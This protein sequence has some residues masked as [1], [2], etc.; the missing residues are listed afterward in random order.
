MKDFEYY[1]CL[2]T[3]HRFCNLNLRPCLKNYLYLHRRCKVCRFL[4][5]SF[6]Y[7]VVKSQWLSI[8][9]VIFLWY[10]DSSSKKQCAFDLFFSVFTGSLLLGPFLAE[11]D[12]RLKHARRS[13]F[14]RLKYNSQQDTAMQQKQYKVSD[15]VLE[16]NRLKALGQS[17]GHANT[18]ER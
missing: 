7:G 10:P 13:V 15:W 4:K 3:S 1:Q 2:H 8:H 5:I 14:C 18:I 12:P 9:I 11:M 16:I 17:I 6:R